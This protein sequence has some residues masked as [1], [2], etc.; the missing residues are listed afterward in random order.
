MNSTRTTIRVGGVPEHFN[1]P[2]KLAQDEGLFTK[3]GVNVVFEEQSCGTGAMLQALHAN[4]LDVCVALTE[5]LVKDMANGSDVRIIGSYVTSRLTWA[6]SVG[7]ASP[8]HSIDD[9]KGETFAISRFTSGSH[10]MAN[11]LAATLGWTDDDVT[12][13]VKGKFSALRESVND[14]S[15]AAFLW[16]TFTTKPYHLTGEVRRIGEITSPW[17][18]FMIAAMKQTVDSKIFAIQ[19]MLGA[20]NEAAVMFHERNST[21]PGVIEEEYGLTAEDAA[22]WYKGVQID[23]ERFVSKAA[24]EEALSMLRKI[25]AVDS[26]VT[27]VATFVDDRVAELVSHK[28]EKPKTLDVEAGRA[29]D[30]VVSKSCGIEAENDVDRPCLVVGKAGKIC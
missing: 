11:V 12:F 15:T 29:L 7:A 8:Y 5:G 17:P 22:A 18:C 4:D 25:G 14:G 9:L 3:W 16:E 23:A 28:S 10:I 21:M 19:G 24:L 2:W 26:T 20:I 30:A 1:Y 6:V 13:A 27:D